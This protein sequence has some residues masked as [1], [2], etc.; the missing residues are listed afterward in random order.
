MRCSLPP[1]LLLLRSP[2]DALGSFPGRDVLTQAQELHKFCLVGI[3]IEGRAHR[4]N[5]L[6]E[7]LESLARTRGVLDK[8]LRHVSFLMQAQDGQKV[9]EHL[10]ARLVNR[11]GVGLPCS[12]ALAKLLREAIAIL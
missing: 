12:E 2:K 7:D 11:C 4:F 6:G 1:L 3:G 5:N 8:D 10:T 9:K